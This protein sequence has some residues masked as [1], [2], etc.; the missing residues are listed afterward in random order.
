MIAFEERTENGGLLYRRQEVENDCLRFQFVAWCAVGKDYVVEGL[1][2]CSVKVC[3]VLQF[4][5]LDADSFRQNVAFLLSLSK[6]NNRQTDGQPNPETN[7]PAP[8]H[9]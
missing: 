9:S 6:R 8:S 7:Q 4:T 3:Q 1:E 5:A 2:T